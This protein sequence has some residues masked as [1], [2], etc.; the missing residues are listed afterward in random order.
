MNYRSISTSPIIFDL[1][2]KNHIRWDTLLIDKIFFIVI[3]LCI[4]LTPVTLKQSAKL[5][6]TSLELRF[7]PTHNN[8]S[9]PIQLVQT[10]PLYKD[11]FY[12]DFST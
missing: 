8:P 7:N 4:Y 9:T 10:I 2:I 11:H 6:I 3:W 5:K 12:K 1:I